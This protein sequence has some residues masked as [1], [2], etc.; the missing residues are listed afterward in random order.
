MSKILIR[1]VSHSLGDTIASL[2]YIEKFGQVNPDSELYVSINNNFI[3]LFESVYPTLKFIKKDCDIVF[4]KILPLEY[5]FNT[6]VQYGYAKQ[7]GFID[8]PYLRPKVTIPNMERPIKSKYITIGTHSTSQLKYWNSPSG[9]KSQLE[10]PNWNELCGMLRKKGYTPVVL[11]QH[12]TFGVVPYWNG[13]PSKANKK[14]GQSLLETMNYIQH[15]E[16]YIGLSSGISWVAHAMGK[17]VVMISNFT[18]DWNEFDLSL[19][20]YKRITN[21]TVCHGCWNMVKKE[22]S[23]DPNNWYWCPR[24]ENTEREF[25]CHKSITPEMVFDQIKDWLD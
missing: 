8:G 22:H 23:F 20:D 16:F 15:S 12:E 24:H 7:L 10:S 17:P 25:E 14:F 5:N 18:E 4:D 1:M 21:K 3:N 6:S 19:S 9:R 13:I 11:E 2:P